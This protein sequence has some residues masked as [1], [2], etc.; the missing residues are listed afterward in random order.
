MQ[1]TKRPPIPIPLQVQVYFRDAWL[2]HVCRKPVIFHL[3]LKHLAGLVQQRLPGATL[4]YWDR[5]WRRDQAPLLDELAAS[6]DHIEAFSRGGVHGLDNF[7]TIC[8]RCNA[9]KS[10][11]STE[12]FVTLSQPW[13]VKGKHGEP[14]HWDGLASAFVALA[15]DRI[16]S[17]SATERKWLAA[18]EQHWGSAANEQR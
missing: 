14:V 12:S 11:R 3:S 1:A 9:R 18:L 5:T 7:A 8:A 15:R 17:L 10:A 6:I 16:N 13:K 4:A 2:C